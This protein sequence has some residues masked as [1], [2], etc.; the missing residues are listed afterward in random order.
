[1]TCIARCLPGLHPSTPGSPTSNRSNEGR[2]LEPWKLAECFAAHRR[3]MPSPQFGVER[4]A[5]MP[6]TTP[7]R[8]FFFFRKG[9]VSKNFF[10]FHEFSCQQ[11]SLFLRPPL[12]RGRSHLAASF[13]VPIS[14]VSSRPRRIHHA[15]RD[16][17]SLG[18]P[19]RRQTS[20]TASALSYEIAKLLV[21][22]VPNPDLGRLAHKAATFRTGHPNAR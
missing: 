20:R 1:M 7:T 8:H 5:M 21:S 9:F 2:W 22:F 15:E 16:Y 13:S 19:N 17:R 12:G 4:S 10:G 11:V 6:N 18:I 3:A 14:F